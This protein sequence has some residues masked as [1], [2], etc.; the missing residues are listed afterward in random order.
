MNLKIE[1]DWPQNTTCIK[2]SGKM[3]HASSH[4]VRWDMHMLSSERQFNYAQVV[5]TMCWPTDLKWIEAP[6]SSEQ[7]GQCLSLHLHLA[8]RSCWVP[9]RLHNPARLQAGPLWTLTQTVLIPWLLLSRW[10]DGFSSSG[11]IEQA[12]AKE[13]LEAE[14]G[15][16]SYASK[17]G[18]SHTPRPCSR[19]SAHLCLL[20][21]CDTACSR[22]MRRFKT[23]QGLVL[24]IR[25]TCVCHRL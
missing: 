23:E 5:H 18:C 10:V 2:P 3:G 1:T 13:C 22:H 11:A 25:P 16:E 7:H 8:E 15:D 21:L 24:L 17:V 6:I 14:G 12:C 19:M 9:I 4:Q 20:C